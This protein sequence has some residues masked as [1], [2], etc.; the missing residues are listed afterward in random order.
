M[1][2]YLLQCL[3]FVS[4]MLVNGLVTMPLKLSIFTIPFNVSQT[5]ENVDKT[6]RH[7]VLP[8]FIHEVKLIFSP[9]SQTV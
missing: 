5:L 3:F 6:G 7:N 1:I 8:S 2:M 4:L 9:I